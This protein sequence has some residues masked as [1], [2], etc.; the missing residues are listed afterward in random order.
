M[1]NQPRNGWIKMQIEIP[2]LKGLSKNSK[3]MESVL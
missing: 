3:K 2:I 1:N